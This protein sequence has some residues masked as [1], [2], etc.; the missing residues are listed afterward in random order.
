MGKRDE[1]WE[2]V[3][4]SGEKWIQVGKSDEKWVK[5]EKSGNSGGK[6]RKVYFLSLVY[7][8]ANSLLD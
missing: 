8:R 1:K 2:T 7:W 6:W 4:K 3:G 5:V